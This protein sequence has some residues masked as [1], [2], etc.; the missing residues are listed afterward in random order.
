MYST[1]KYTHY[2]KGK[3]ELGKNN[4]KLK[5]VS[6][7]REKENLISRCPRIV[8]T[9]LPNLKQEKNER[10]QDNTDKKKKKIN[11]EKEKRRNTWNSR[12]P[13]TSGINLKQLKNK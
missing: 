7:E 4:K 9:K 2:Y 1:I 3:N 12:S 13:V 5:S 10:V 11:W 8:T 6:G